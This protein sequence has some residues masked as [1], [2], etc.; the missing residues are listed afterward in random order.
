MGAVMSTTTLPD[1]PIDPEVDCT[2]LDSFMLNTERLLGSELVAMSSHAVIGA[3]LLLWCRAWKQRPAASLPDDDKVLAGFASMHISRWRKLREQ[4]LHGFVKCSDGRLYHPVLASDAAKAFAKKIRYREKVTQ[5]T[6]HKRVMRKAKKAR[7]SAIFGED[8]ALDNRSYTGT[9]TGTETEEESKPSSE[10][11]TPREAGPTGPAD[12]KKDFFAFEGR[13]LRVRQRDFDRWK[14]SYHSIP[15]LWA[16]LDAI[17]VRLADD[18]HFDD[19]KWY[20]RVGAWLRTIHQNNLA[21]KPGGGTAAA[22][23][24]SAGMA[25][26]SESPQHWRDR[27]R[28]WF[29]RQQ[30]SPDPDSWPDTWG[31]PLGDPDCRVPPDVL[32][33]FRKAA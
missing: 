18:P 21:A 2:D 3:A 15:D 27:L 7:N 29:D 1:P 33:E 19:R 28:V 10:S 32:A 30:G 6:N 23:N 12:G 24:G 26:P 5:A 20:A 14:A 8:V 25:Y 31:P 17:D 22:S 4:I 13:V 16:A 11:R 9:V